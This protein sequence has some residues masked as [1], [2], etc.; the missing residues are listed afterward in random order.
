MDTIIS[1]EIKN[2]HEIFVF[3]PNVAIC[4]PMKTVQGEAVNTDPGARR[5]S[6]Q[7]YFELRA[8]LQ[9]CYSQGILMIPGGAIGTLSSSGII[10][11]VRPCT[12]P[13]LREV[14]EPREKIEKMLKAKGYESWESIKGDIRYRYDR[15]W[16]DSTLFSVLAYDDLV[17]GFETKTNVYRPFFNKL[18]PDLIVR[19]DNRY[20][21]A[22]QSRSLHKVP[23]ES[24]ITVIGEFQQHVIS[25]L[26]GAVV[27]HTPELIGRLAALLHQKHLRVV[28]EAIIAMPFL[29]KKPSME[30]NLANAVGLGLTYAHFLGFAVIDTYPKDEDELAFIVSGDFD[31]WLYSHIPLKV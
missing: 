29:K 27:E 8:A 1:S 21:W 6:A 22:G 24:V 25:L 3:A 10:R 20:T 17:E 19:I 15:R 7:K 13:H 11:G 23:L 16:E 9:A 30:H 28:K 31:K 26:S 12:V 2:N 14:Y 4:I 18:D 5:N